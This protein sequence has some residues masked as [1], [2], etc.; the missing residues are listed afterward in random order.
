[1]ADEKTCFIAD[2]HIG[3]ESR[4]TVCMRGFKSDWMRHEQ[5]VLKGMNRTLSRYHTLYILGDV[6]SS[7]DYDHLKWFLQQL[8]TKRIF[9]VLG[10]HDNEQFFYRLKKEHVILDYALM[11][12]IKFD[13][14]RFVLC[15][16]PFFE[17]PHF[18]ANGFHLFGHTHNNIQLGWRSMDVG[19]DNIG[20]SPIDIKEVIRQLERYNNV[21]QYRN[22]LFLDKKY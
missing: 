10:N 3:S 12:D 14:K 19:I 7:S 22:K 17:W 5:E 9:L 13:K 21:D 20:Y 4:R 18:F 8:K 1:M 16:Y 15:H 2:L 11:Y 6:G